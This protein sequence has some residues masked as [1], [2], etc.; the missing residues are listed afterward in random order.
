MTFSKINFQKEETFLKRHFQEYYKKNFVGSVPEVERREFGYGVFGRK[1]ADRNI[2]FS[3]EKIVNDFLFAQVPLFF[4]YSTA[5]YRY[6]NRKPMEAKELLGADIVYE[7]DADDIQTSCKEKHDSWKCPKGHFGKGA[8]EN[9]P[10]CGEGVEVSQWFCSECL[11]EA[12]R[13]VFRLIDFLKDDFGFT[14]GIEVN[15]SGKA[16]YHIHLQGKEIRNLGRGARIEL[17]DYLTA[18]GMFFEKLGYGISSAPITCPR[19]DGAWR[20]RLNKGIENLFEKD[21]ERV[22][23]FTGFSIKKMKKFFDL[24]QEVLSGMR[25]GILFPAEGR[26]SKEFW[27]KILEMVAGEEMLPIDR[28]TSIDLHKIIR[29]PETLHGE[30][31]FCAKRIPVGELKKFDPFTDPVVF[32]DENLFGSGLVKVFISKAPRFSLCGQSFGPFENEES[33][34]PLFCAIYLIGKGAVLR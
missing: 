3:S 10:E 19:E 33:E 34:V 8:I 23:A 31:G 27:K 26:K 24:K 18:S 22:A 15:F 14:E 1:I 20:K 17:V 4:S 16:G 5:Y 32:A 11:G 21:P 29:V 13:H 30:T 12:K 2:S 7:F 9:C 25:R 28:Q 6:P